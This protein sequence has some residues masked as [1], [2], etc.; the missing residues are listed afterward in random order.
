MEETT[1]G[2]ALAAAAR[3]CLK[4]KKRELEDQVC[5]ILRFQSRTECHALVA[6]TLTHARVNWASE[7]F[8]D[9]FLICRWVLMIQIDQDNAK[10]FKT[11]PTPC[12]HM[13]AIPSGYNESVLTLPA[14]LH[15]TLNDPIWTGEMAKSYP[16][17]LDTF[18]S[19]AVACIVRC[20]AFFGH[21]FVC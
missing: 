10:R 6:L 9:I 4:S 1:E 14:P 15:G 21:I 5:C 11:S 2:L 16:F 20:H 19:K 18:Q 3:D 7:Y 12:R 8:L 17:D 13:V